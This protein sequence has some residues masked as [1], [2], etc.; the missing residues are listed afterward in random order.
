MAGGVCDA[1]GE[2]LI[3]QGQ[4]D[5]LCL[6]AAVWVDPAAADEEAVYANN[7]AATVAA[8]RAGALRRPTLAD[9]LA[10]GSEPANPYFRAR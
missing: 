10:A 5:D 3:A 9:V 6:I 7:R 1:V 4:I 2:G 8:L